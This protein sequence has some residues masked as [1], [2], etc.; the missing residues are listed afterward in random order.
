[1]I[2]HIVQRVLGVIAVLALSMSHGAARQKKKMA[3]K[4]GWA[5]DALGR[6]Y[7]YAPLNHH[8]FNF[9]VRRNLCMSQ[10]W[11]SSFLNS[12]PVQR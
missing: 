6:Q 12:T 4:S 1:M 7:S 8:N 10:I 11:T 2:P 3:P 5:L 9:K